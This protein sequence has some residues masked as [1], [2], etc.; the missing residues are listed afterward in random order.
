MTY[1]IPFMQ[2]YTYNPGTSGSICWWVDVSGRN[3]NGTTPLDVCQGSRSSYLIRTEQL[4]AGCRSSSF[5]SALNLS[6]SISPNASSGPCSPGNS[7]WKYS[8]S[9]FPPN[10]IATVGFA[11]SGLPALQLVPPSAPSGACW[12]YVSPI[13][14][15]LSRLDQF[16]DALT[17]VLNINPLFPFLGVYRAALLGYEFDPAQLM[18]STAWAVGF[19]VV[20]VTMFVRY[21]GKMVRYL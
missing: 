8:G 19:L 4:G 7:S 5:G 14:W 2:P 20:G 15:P 17:S 21:E 12:L 6:L 18:A 11:T 10:G 3:N 9:R 1:T 13:I 16:P